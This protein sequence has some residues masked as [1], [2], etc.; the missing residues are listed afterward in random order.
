[1]PVT[2]VSKQP[3][4]RRT[5]SLTPASWLA[6]REMIGLTILLEADAQTK[7]LDLIILLWLSAWPPC[8]EQSD[9]HPAKYP[10]QPSRL[11]LLPHQQYGR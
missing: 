5:T 1:M 7:S 9:G 11:G 10:A 3:S 4:Y 8:V 2:Q 6:H